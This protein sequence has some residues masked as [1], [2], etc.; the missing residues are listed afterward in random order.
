MRF[1]TLEIINGVPTW[2]LVRGSPSW[3]QGRKS[4]REG[5][6]AI[7]FFIADDVKLVVMMDRALASVGTNGLAVAAAA[8]T[9]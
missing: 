8:C 5:E 2:I 1:S 4:Q 3:N 9:Y 6:H 7:L